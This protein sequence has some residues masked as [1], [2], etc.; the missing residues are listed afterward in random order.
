M[1][2]ALRRGRVSQEGVFAGVI[3]ETESGFRFTYDSTYLADPSTPPVSLT[4]PKRAA[5]YQS[6]HLFA[7]FQGLLAEGTLKTVQCRQLGLD[8]EDDFGR[9]L[10]TLK[11]DFVGSVSVVPEEG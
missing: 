5:P 8:E 6:P 1:S 2:H 9:L 4:L 11:G 10:A 7:F 3:E